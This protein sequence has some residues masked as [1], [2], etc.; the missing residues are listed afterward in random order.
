MRDTVSDEKLQ[1]EFLTFEDV[2]LP[3][4]HDT[5]ACEMT[6]KIIDLVKNS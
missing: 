1:V 3:S 6:A 2:K 4:F 5:P